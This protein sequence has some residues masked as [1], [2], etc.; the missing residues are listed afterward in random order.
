MARH[1]YSERPNYNK[2]EPQG[3]RNL[4]SGDDTYKKRRKVIEQIYD[5]KKLAKSIGV[6]LPRIEARIV[7]NDPNT[8]K[9]Q[10][11]N[12][13]V[14]IARMNTNQIWIPENTLVGQYQPYLKEIVFHE[15]LHASFGIQHDENCPL[16]RS[17]L[18]QP[19]PDNIV[20]ELF[21]KHIKKVLNK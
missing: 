19:I 20:N 16:M 21:L 14:G 10:H 6:E 18:G 11:L 15:I 5:A 13:A 12:N 17:K 8:V 1:D 4:K 9:A 2:K 7:E 3:F